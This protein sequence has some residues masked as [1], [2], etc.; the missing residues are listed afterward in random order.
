MQ[1]D[2]GKLTIAA[3]AINGCAGVAAGKGVSVETHYTLACRAAV[4]ELRA[5]GL[6]AHRNAE[7]EIQ[8]GKRSMV[9]ERGAR[10]QILLG[11]HAMR[12][13]WMLPWAFSRHRWPRYDAVCRRRM[14]DQDG[15]SSDRD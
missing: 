3:A 2:I 14:I 8:R 6:D 11:R 4:E 7:W 9:A 10:C 12:A 1:S 5:S 13:A 15:N